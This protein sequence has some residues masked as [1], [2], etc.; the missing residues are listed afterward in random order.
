MLIA[1]FVGLLLVAL[2]AVWLK[3]RHD[4]K[5]DQIRGGFNEGITTRPAH[6]RHEKDGGVGYAANDSTFL[7]NNGSQF[8]PG[9]GRD[10]PARTREAFMPYGYGYAR[11]ES[12]VGSRTDVDASAITTPA[13]AR[14]GTPAREV[15]KG[16]EIQPA[17]S[18]KP[19]QRRVLVRERS[20]QEPMSPVEER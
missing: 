18:K 10:S 19:G 15:E 4:R 5:Q 6:H 3:R 9:S 13:A 17:A 12:R 11:S 8:M 14:G 7:S 20:M 1:I 2:V 16:D